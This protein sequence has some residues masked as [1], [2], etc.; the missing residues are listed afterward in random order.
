VLVQYARYV[1]FLKWMSL[2]L[3]AYFGTLLMV[4]I[5]LRA[6]AWGLLVPTVHTTKDFT[7]I[8]V[9]V[10]GTTISPYLFFWRNCSSLV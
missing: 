6:V 10:L 3:C 2:V 8:V 9:A 5:P 4:H 1:A 7:S